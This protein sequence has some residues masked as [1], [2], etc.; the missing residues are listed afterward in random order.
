M[1]DAIESEEPSLSRSLERVMQQ[2][3][4]MK[5]AGDVERMVMEVW[6]VLVEL[7]FDFVSCAILLI[8]EERD[9]MTTYNIWEERR[10]TSTEPMGKGSNVQKKERARADKAKR[11][12]AEGKGGGG[13]AAMAVRKGGADA[14]AA[15]K[16]WYPHVLLRVI[17][18]SHH[19]IL[20]PAPYASARSSSGT[21]VKESGKG[22]ACCEERT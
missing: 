13:Q 10:L 2:V 14:A 16:F 8:D 21:R 11:A 7:G 9:W 5:R 18:L 15:S 12:A 6:E 3:L 4:G 17:V 19:S 22:R 20:S 1:S